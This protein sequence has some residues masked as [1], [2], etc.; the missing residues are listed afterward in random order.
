MYS[1]CQLLSGCEFE[2]TILNLVQK[3]PLLQMYVAG[4]GHS[5]RLVVP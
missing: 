1:F 5:G 3:R 4:M 2:V